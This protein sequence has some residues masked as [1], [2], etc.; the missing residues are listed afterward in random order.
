MV[1]KLWPP[2]KGGQQGGEAVTDLGRLSRRP[3]RR[4][5]VDPHDLADSRSEGAEMPAGQRPRRCINEM[6]GR[7]AEPCR[8]GRFAADGIFLPSWK[9]SQSLN[10]RGVP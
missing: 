1:P 10:V 6:Q 7:E 4:P 9:F 8:A 2:H 5:R 3:G